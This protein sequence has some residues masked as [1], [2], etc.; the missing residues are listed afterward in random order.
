MLPEITAF[1]ES[2]AITGTARST[3]ENY[4]Y[5]LQAFDQFIFDAVL[6]G[7]L[8]AYEISDDTICPEAFSLFCDRLKDN[9]KSGKTVQQYLTIVKL[10]AKSINKPVEFSYRITSE[11]KKAKQIKNINRWFDE[12]DVAACLNWQ[13]PTAKDS[14]TR[15][16]SRLLIRMLA[17]TGARISEIANMK[18]EDVVQEERTVFISLSKT[19][20]RPAF[21]SSETVVLMDQFLSDNTDVLGGQIAQYLFPDVDKCQSIVLG[22]LNSLKMKQPQD[23]RGPHTFRH[24]VA[25]RLYFVGGMD[26]TDLAIVLGDKPDTIRDNYLHPTAEMLR[27][28]VKKAWRW[29]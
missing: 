7:E 23:G 27:K 6:A 28:K 11:D 12:S 25:T 18:I 26:L 20:P 21:Y 13:F 22:M 29:V 2:A 15:L 1:L 4:K 3:Q 24:F 5:S 19:E 10:F 9:N 16:Q 14:R 17:E 8:P